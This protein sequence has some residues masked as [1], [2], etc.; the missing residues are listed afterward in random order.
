MVTAASFNHLCPLLAMLD[1]VH[2]LAPNHA[3]VVYDLDP[4]PPFIV[5][6][7]LT[8]VHPK[9]EPSLNSS[10]LYTAH[11]LRSVPSLPPTLSRPH[12]VVPSFHLQSA[13]SVRRQEATY[14]EGEADAAC[15][16]THPL[17]STWQGG[18]ATVQI[19]RLPAVL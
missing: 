18:T 12:P 8:R 4:E 17:H 5:E 15:P 3:V 13:I 11:H 6:S 7:W 10:R 9:F 1:S 19:R 16:H 2:R 14:N